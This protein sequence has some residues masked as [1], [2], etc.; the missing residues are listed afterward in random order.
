MNKHYLMESF[1][2]RN[3]IGSPPNVQIIS[4]AVTSQR[5]VILQLL[6][7]VNFASFI[8]VT[9]PKYVW[10]TLNKITSET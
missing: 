10:V 8:F 9:L 4:R 2:M 3:R 1:L 6:L 5:L 7:F